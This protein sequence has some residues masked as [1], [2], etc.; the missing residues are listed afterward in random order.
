MMPWTALALAVLLMVVARRLHRAEGR[1]EQ[2]WKNVMALN[3]DSPWAPP[4]HPMCRC[5]IVPSAEALEVLEGVLGGVRELWRVRAALSPGLPE[6]AAADGRITDSVEV[7]GEGCWCTFVPLHL[8]VS[9]G[10]EDE[11]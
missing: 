2:L 10:E 8:T 6:C 7:H 5:V 3:R 1:L 9:D 11:E 4:S